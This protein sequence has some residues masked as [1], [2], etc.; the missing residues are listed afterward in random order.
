VPER[1]DGFQIPQIVSDSVMVE[2]TGF[3]DR[4]GAIATTT[5]FILVLFAPVFVLAVL[6][7][8]RD[9]GERT[10]NRAARPRPDNVFKFERWVR[11]PKRMP[12]HTH[13]FRN[14][15]LKAVGVILIAGFF[16]LSNTSVQADTK[17]V[18]VP[19]NKVDIIDVIGA[20]DGDS[21]SSLL[22][23]PKIR[24]S[25][26]NGRLNVELVKIE[27]PKGACQGK[28]VQVLAVQYRPKRGFRGKDEGSVTYWA[29]PRLYH[30]RQMAIPRARK[31]IIT[32]K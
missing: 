9:I 22:S 15:S 21:C 20:I 1:I 19:A 4:F 27:A 31:Y 6:A 17:K 26:K 24:T 16:A 2:I 23:N 10:S 12:S 13:E 7:G 11:S 32:V 25:P 8:L 28:T 30:E 5:G 18:K 3:I 14:V 29:P